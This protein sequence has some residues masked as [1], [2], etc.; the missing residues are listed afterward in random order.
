MTF[1]PLGDDN[2]IE[3]QSTFCIT[4]F[5]LVAKRSFMRTIII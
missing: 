1:I 5:I 4:V 2:V 3:F